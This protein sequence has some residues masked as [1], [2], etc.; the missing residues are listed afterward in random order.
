MLLPFAFQNPFSKL[1]LELLFL[2][3]MSDHVI[4]LLQTLQWLS[5]VYGVGTEVLKMTYKVLPDLSSSLL[6]I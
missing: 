2:Q 1:Q 3:R 4:F 5:S 6:P